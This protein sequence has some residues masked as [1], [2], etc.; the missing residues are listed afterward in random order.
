VAVQERRVQWADGRRCAGAY[1]LI[2]E[3]EVHMAIEAKLPASA[4]RLWN[5]VGIRVSGNPDGWRIGIEELKRET[6]LSGPSLWRAAK[7]L[8]EAG[9]VHKQRD[10]VN[11]WTL[12]DGHCPKC[13]A[14]K[15]PK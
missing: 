11:R 5:Y 14:K 13:R 15:A 2:S 9:L 8:E 3:A 7:K 4:W 12:C 10:G 1:F 6:D